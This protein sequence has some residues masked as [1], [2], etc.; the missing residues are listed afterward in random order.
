MSDHWKD[1]PDYVI[2]AE[3]VK[4]Q[5]PPEYRP[6]IDAASC[7]AWLW[8]DSG[9]VCPEME[10]VLRSYCQQ[11]WQQAQVEKG[12]NAKQR[13]TLDPGFQKP[14]YKAVHAHNR[15]T[16]KYRKKGYVSEGRIVDYLLSEFKTALGPLPE[17]DGTWSTAKTSHGRVVVKPTASYHAIIVEGVIVC[18]L[19]H[20][21]PARLCVDIVGALVSPLVK[22]CTDLKVKGFDTSMK[23]P[24]RIPTN[25][26]YK[27][28]PC[29]HRIA[30]FDVNSVE[31]VVKCIK[32]VFAIE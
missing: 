19:W 29:T 21:V 13:I 28:R 6:H 25:S 2:Q 3:R 11:A 24:Y 4:A 17:T 32:R 7:F 18:R 27:C 10:C 26:L 14:H 31:P 1:Q 9:F 20:D 30:L 12:L 16:G 8:E 5:A 22:V 15:K 23:P